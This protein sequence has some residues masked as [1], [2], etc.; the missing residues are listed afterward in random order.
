MTLPKLTVNNITASFA[1]NRT[2]PIESMGGEARQSKTNWAVRYVKDDYTL[3]CK[4]FNSIVKRIATSRKQVTALI[5]RS[6]SVVLVGGNSRKSVREALHSFLN[7]YEC[8]LSKPLK[9]SNFAMSFRY[10]TSLNLVKLYDNI[11]AFKVPELVTPSYEV[12]LF[13]S[14]IVRMRYHNTK[15]SIFTS[16]KVIITGCKEVRNGK[17]MMQLLLSL[18]GNQ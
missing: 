6:G 15:A 9:F 2:F 5:Y 3:V 16:G 14:L 11:L 10:N 4:Q 7:L 1:V 13:P 8:E 17:H 12:E 18:F